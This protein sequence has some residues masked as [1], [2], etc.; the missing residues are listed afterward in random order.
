MAGVTQKRKKIKPYFHCGPS[1][2]ISVFVFGGR[3]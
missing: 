2:K 1:K 3:R